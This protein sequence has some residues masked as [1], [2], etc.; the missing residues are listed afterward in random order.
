MNSEVI[1]EPKFL[2]DQV[3]SVCIVPMVPFKNVLLNKAGGLHSSTDFSLFR[4]RVCVCLC[5]FAC[6]PACLNGVCV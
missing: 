6:L 2:N 4:V 1:I 5:V 3:Y